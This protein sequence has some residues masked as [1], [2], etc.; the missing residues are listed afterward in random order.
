MGSFVSQELKLFTLNRLLNPN[1]QF[2]VGNWV[3]FAD[4]AGTAPVD[5]TGGSP[6]STITR[7]ESTP[8]DGI[9]SLLFT[10]NTGA[11]RQG[12]GASTDFVL[13]ASDATKVFTLSVDYQITTGTYTEGTQTTQ[14]DLTWWFYDVTNSVMYQMTP[15][16][17]NGT[18]STTGQYN[19]QAQVQIPVG[20]LTGRLIM[21]IPT[22]TNASCTLR[23]NNI[24]F[25]RLPRIQGNVAIPWTAYT[26]TGAWSANT[27]YTAY[28][29]RVG[30]TLDL[31]IK[32]ATSG[33]PTSASLTVNL[34][35]G[36]SIDTAKVTDTTA[37]VAAWNSLAVA[38]DASTESYECFVVYN[39][40]TSIA[41]MKDD[42][43]GTFSAV[44]QAAPFTFGS[45]DFVSISVSGIPILGW[46]ANGTLGQDADTRV[47]AAKYTLAG[48]T[49]VAPAASDQPFKFD[50]LSYD[51]HMAATYG[52][53]A[54]FTYFAPVGGYYYWTIGYHI[55]NTVTFTLQGTVYIINAMINGTSFPGS[56]LAEFFSPANTAY[57]PSI[58]GN[59]GHYLNA[60]D[61]LTFT[62]L[63]DGTSLIV[64]IRPTRNYI[65]I[66]RMSGPAQ[67]QA[68]EV[69][70][71]GYN[72]TAAQSIANATTAIVNFDTKIYDTF[73]AV[74]TGASWKFTSPRAGTVRVAAFITFASG[75]FTINNRIQLYLYKNGA[76][77]EGLNYT[78]IMA[79]VTDP[80]TAEGG[81]DVQVI[82]GDTLDIRVSHGEATARALTSTATE[83][84][85][86]ISY[87][88]GF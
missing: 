63:S 3:A 40:T 12:E 11:S 7:S 84:Y 43:D 10:K 50:T 4:A 16:N 66:H 52:S 87:T 82:A 76:L 13:Q 19:M 34:P 14:S 78:T 59:G 5:G 47:V 23:F 44:T 79:T 71:A 74:T 70:K 88:D 80:I 83:N 24:T 37:A 60:G 65:E 69:P 67:V 41:I 39:N 26:P 53:A 64:A 56:C 15:S 38:R 46:G 55:A 68:N 57:S 72:T 17:I 62:N 73:G 51:T 35:S 27:T 31:Q 20:C 48:A 45:G 1:T 30:D 29:R 42:G 8:L 49:Y 32:V 18:V 21:Y 22:T 85:V 2:S 81:T 61:K 36:L 28:W 54:T 25:G 75:I 77:Y 6:N 58:V 9:A 33:A 86:A